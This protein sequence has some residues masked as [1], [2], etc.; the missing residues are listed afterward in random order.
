MKVPVVVIGGGLSGLQVASMLCA[1]GIKCRILESRDRVGGR[2][3]TV[4]IDGNRELGGYDLGPAG[5]WPE[6]QP[7]VASLV[8]ELGLGTFSQ[9]TGGAMLVERFRYE[10]AQRSAGV[11]SLTSAVA[12][13]LPVGVIQ[14]NARVVAISDRGSEGVLLEVQSGSRLTEVIQADMVVMALPPRVIARHIRF[15]PMLPPNLVTSLLAAPTWL[16]GQ[17]K[18]V[19]VYARPFWR[20]AG[21]SG[22]ASS[23]VG[24]LQEIHDASPT[25]EA[26]AL[27]G[28]FAMSATMRKGLGKAAVRALVIAQFELLFGPLAGRPLG[29]L[30]KDWAEDPN[31]AVDDDLEPV[32]TYPIYGPPN[33]SGK[34]WNGLISE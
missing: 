8:S 25:G 12:G 34:L 10:R 1:R 21:R 11:G 31:T 6:H 2:A 13:K 3:L 9:P 22:L 16:A 14:L 20:E 18:A 33:E 5:F 32:N 30:Y 19:A 17:A 7:L 27:V 24:P 4:G 15:H 28:F 23:V 29:F 26:G